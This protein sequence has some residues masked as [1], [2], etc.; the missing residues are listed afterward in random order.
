[1][2]HEIKSSAAQITTCRNPKHI[3][4]SVIC[5]CTRFPKNIPPLWEGPSAQKYPAGPQ[6]RLSAP[7]FEVQEEAGRVIGSQ[8]VWLGWPQYLEIFSI[9]WLQ[10]L[11]IFNIGWLQYLEI[12]PLVALWEGVRHQCAT[13]PQAVCNTSPMPTHLNMATLLSTE[14]WNGENWYLQ[15][16]NNNHIN[17]NINNSQIY[18]SLFHE[19][20]VTK[21]LRYNR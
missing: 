10:Y 14:M 18:K 20:R 6:A 5:L 19:E 17:I 3:T 7:R 1:M 8:V 4:V 9:G 13:R 16:N 15:N 11:E 21:T 12:L 2:I